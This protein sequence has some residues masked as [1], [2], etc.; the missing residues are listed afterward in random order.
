MIRQAGCGQTSKDF[1]FIL[2]M[3]S[4]SES[5]SDEGCSLLVNDKTWPW[6]APRQIPDGCLMRPAAGTHGREHTSSGTLCLHIVV[7]LSGRCENSFDQF[8]GWR[9]V[10]RF[11]DRTERDTELMEKSRSEK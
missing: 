8:A 3:L 9:I 1:A 6:P 11:S 10:D 5:G 2:A 7:E 4:L